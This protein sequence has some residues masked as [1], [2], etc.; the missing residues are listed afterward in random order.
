MSFRFLKRIKR[1]GGLKTYLN[2]T[3]AE[4][5]AEAKPFWNE[6]S[7]WFAQQ[8]A[9]SILLGFLLAARTWLLPC[10][11]QTQKTPFPL[12]WFCSLFIMP[13]HSFHIILSSL[14]QKLQ[15]QSFQNGIGIQMSHTARKVKKTNFRKE[16]CEFTQSFHWMQPRAVVLCCFGANGWIQDHPIDHLLEF[17]EW[18]SFHCFCPMC[19]NADQERE[20][21]LFDEWSSQMLCVEFAWKGRKW[22]MQAPTQWS[23]SCLWAVHVL[24]FCL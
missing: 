12:K 21:L 15:Q 3:L 10:G 2:F 1:L 13:L 9:T 7:D 24:H 14:W 23:N 11:Y 8:F 20:F 4:V 22:A 16:D 5:D 19:W 18:I 17:H 6:G